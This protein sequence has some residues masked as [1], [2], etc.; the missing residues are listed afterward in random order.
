MVKT[1]S[2]GA[3]DDLPKKLGVAEE[4]GCTAVTL[5]AQTGNVSVLSFLHESGVC[6]HGS[7]LMT[8]GDNSKMMASDMAPIH[9]ASS[10]GHFQ[11]LQRLLELGADVNQFT[12]NEPERNLYSDTPLHIACRDGQLKC[13]ELL[14]KNGADISAKNCWGNQPLHLACY[15]GY[16]AVVQRLIAAGCDLN[17]VNKRRETAL[18]YAVRYNHYLIAQLLLHHGADKSIANLKNKAAIDFLKEELEVTKYNEKKKDAIQKM[19]RLLEQESWEMPNERL[20]DDYHSLKAEVERLHSEVEELKEKQNEE[21]EAKLCQICCEKEKNSV[22]VPCGHVT[23]CLSCSKQ[24]A[25]QGHNCPACRGVI[26][27]V[28]QIYIV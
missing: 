12:K 17:A 20:I 9:R 28:Y 24:I 1:L 7:Y 3:F 14:L 4:S 27:A 2:L 6:I 10:L 16:F 8:K 13:V 26:Q 5:T 22:F 15:K 25:D 23:S 18:H 11:Y 19:L 21:E